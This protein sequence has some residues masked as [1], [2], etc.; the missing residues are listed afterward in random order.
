MDERFLRNAALIGE[1]KCRVLSEA[2]I[3][4]FGVGGV[5]GYVA[6]TLARLG[7]G[8]ITV[9]DADTVSMSNIN[10]QIIAMTSTVSMKK[11]ELVANRITDINPSAE[12]TAICDFVNENNI[13][14]ILQNSH[15]DFVV[16]AIDT[17]TSKVA[18][19][20]ACKKLNIPI[21]SSMGTGNKLDPTRLKI[22]DISKTNTCPLA[23]TMRLKL[24]T[25]GISDVEVLWSD[26]APRK[27]CADASN[28]RHSPASVAFVPSVAGILIARRVAERIVGGF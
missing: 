14:P 13:Y 4:L 22:S 10:R 16:D 8:S 5:G 7:V 28:G 12:S 19:I 20:R 23:R 26:E 1:D 9:I 3:T 15:P 17:L 18:I 24:R 11:A 27:V 2:R 21:I 6:E 25:E